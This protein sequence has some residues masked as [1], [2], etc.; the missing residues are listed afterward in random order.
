[1]LFSRISSDE[2]TAAPEPQARPLVVAILG[3]VR[4][5]LHDTLFAQLAGLAG[6]R[7]SQ[8]V[9]QRLVRPLVSGRAEP[10]A[11]RDAPSRRRL[12]PPPA[13]AARAHSAGVTLPGALHAAAPLAL[14]PV[15]DAADAQE[16]AGSSDLLL[17]RRRAAQTPQVVRTPN[18]CAITP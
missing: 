4:H 17:R 3:L 2:P 8:L 14:L 9:G 18:V 16:R 6:Q 1:M 11:G 7:Q 15:A 5:Q 13:V 10:R 12:P